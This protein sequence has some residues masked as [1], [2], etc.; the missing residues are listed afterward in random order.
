VRANSKHRRGKPVT[1]SRH[2][3]RDRTP[4]PDPQQDKGDWH[5]TLAN[6]S[7]STME[8]CRP[9]HDRLWSSSGS[10]VAPHASA[11]RTARHKPAWRTGSTSA[12]MASTVN[13]WRPASR[14]ARFR[15]GQN[16]LAAKG[17][18]R[19]CSASAGRWPPVREIPPRARCANQWAIDGKAACRHE[20]QKTVVKRR[21]MRTSMR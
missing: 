5:A 17:S 20:G 7:R 11:R 15:N 14:S 21:R 3:R 2:R 18:A 4:A 10:D 13:I 19:A 16:D 6:G 12:R 1:P 9:S 8:L